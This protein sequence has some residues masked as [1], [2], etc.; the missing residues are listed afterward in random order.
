MKS[1][2]AIGFTNVKIHFDIELPTYPLCEEVRFYLISGKIDP[3]LVR[4]E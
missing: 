2:K 1:C 4:L 3:G